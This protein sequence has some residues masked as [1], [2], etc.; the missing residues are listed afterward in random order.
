MLTLVI[1]GNRIAAHNAAAVYGIAID[2]LIE[3]TKWNETVAVADDKYRQE[4]A[5][6]WFVAGPIERPAAGY[7]PGTL[8]WWGERDAA[9]SAY[10]E[11][12]TPLIK[13]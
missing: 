3:F 2:T 7:E 13:G 8:L 6:R 9:P 5:C 12:I 11:T 1:K 10:R 4:I